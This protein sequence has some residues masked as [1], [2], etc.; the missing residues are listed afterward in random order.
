LGWPAILVENKAKLWQRRQNPSHEFGGAPPRP[1]QQP[2]VAE[3]RQRL[4]LGWTSPQV[5]C[6]NSQSGGAAHYIFRAMFTRTLHSLDFEEKGEVLE[7]RSIVLAMALLAGIWG[8][9]QAARADHVYLP[10]Q[11]VHSE[12]VDYVVNRVWWQE[13][14]VLGADITVIGQRPNVWPPRFFLV[15]G[16]G[17]KSYQKPDRPGEGFTNSV[18]AHFSLA[19]GQQ[20]RRNVFFT[21]GK[22]AQWDLCDEYSS[23][24]GEIPRVVAVL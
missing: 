9:S 11:I 21:V 5:D 13:Q 8:T 20:V 23:H 4:A 10:G 12:G 24:A 14:T 1:V 17:Q 19:V 16:V 3:T 22:N 18:G 6:K 7:M 15:N 2:R